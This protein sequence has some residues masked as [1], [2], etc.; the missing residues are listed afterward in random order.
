[1]ELGIS[2]ATVYRWAGSA[3][4]LVGEV[5]ATLIDDTFTQ[6][7]ERSTQTGSKRVLDVLERGMV[8]AH[9]FEPLR[10]F[11]VANPQSGLRIVASKHG[12]VQART[13]ANLEQLLTEEV[14]NGRL[15][16]PVTPAVMAYALTRI[17]ES[18]LYSDLI[19]GASPDLKSASKVLRM[20]LEST[21]TRE[22]Q[23][24]AN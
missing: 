23:H 5:L 11:L 9:R 1:M 21:D 4:A 16:L 22:P 19:A 17:I 3:D 8:Y 6:L 24:A 18:F 2:R 10:K 7:A 14:A 20:L 12:P 13:I 15:T